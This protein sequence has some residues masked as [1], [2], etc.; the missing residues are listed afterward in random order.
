MTTSAGELIYTVDLDT[1]RLVSGSKRASRAFDEIEHSAANLNPVLSKTYGLMVSISGA[2]AVDRIIKYADAWTVVGNKVTN[3]LK[4]GQD[5]VDVQNA[6]F[7]VAQDSSTPLQ[8]VASLYGRLEPATRG[9]INSG[10]ELIK[11]TETINKAFVVSGATAEEASNAIVQLSQ[12]L[13]AGA[14]RS[15]EFNSVNEQGPRIMQGIADYMG[16]ARGELKSLAAQGKI[17]TEVVINSLRKMSSS[18]DTEFSKMND[19]F[20]MKGAQALNNLTKSL[21]SN[22]EVQSAVSA[23]GDAMV[24]LSENIDTVVTAGQAMATLYGA[25]LV[26][27]IAASTA[28]TVKSRVA[29]HAAAIAASEEAVEVQKLSASLL[30]SARNKVV[31]QKATVAQISAE[32]A[33]LSTAQ[34]SLTAQLSLSASERE[35]TAIRLQL[36]KYSQAMVAAAKAE[37]AAIAQLSVVSKEAA[38]AQ[39]TLA[40]STAAATAASRA[41]T[42][43]LGLLR[44]ALALVGGPAG[45]LLIAAAGVYY[46]YDS[47]KQANSETIE[48]AKSLDATSDSLKKLTSIQAEAAAFKLEKSIQLQSE[49]VSK[50]RDGVSKLSDEYESH[51]KTSRALFGTDKGLS[52]LR[53]ELAIEAERLEAKELEL[54][55]TKNKLHAIQQSLSGSTRDNYVLMGDLSN[56]TSI[57]T[58]IQ[59]E[60]NNVI[61]IGNNALKERANYVSIPESKVSANAQKILDDIKARTEAEKAYGTAKSARILAEKDARD[62]GVTDEKEIQL[63]S[64]A[65]AAQWEVINARKE[66]AKSANDGASEIARNNQLI[67][68]EKLKTQQLNA[69]YT[70]LYATEEKVTSGK[71]R[72]TEASAR[73]EAQQKLSSGASKE[74]IDALAKEIYAQDQM[75]AKLDARIEKE[76]KL[77]ELEGQRDEAKR[78]TEQVAFDAASPLEQIDIEEK[79]KLAKLE[80]YRQLQREAEEAGRQADIISLQEYEATKNNI[81]KQAADERAAI[82]LARN[83]M[84]LSASSDFFGGM[85]DLTGAFAGE[86][87]GAYKALF[88]IGKGFAIANAALQLQT[89]IANA[90]ALPWPENFPAIAQAVALG[91]Q[92]ASNIAGVNYGGARE[93]G[94]P[95]DAGKMYRVGEGGKPEVF[96]SGGKN[97]M[98]PGD[99]GKVIPNDQIGGGGFSQNVQVHNY[100]GENVQTKTSMD[101]KQLEVV[102][103]EVAKQI[104]QRRGGVGR[105]L[106]SS[107][108]T[109]WKAQ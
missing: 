54:S 100:S 44:G 30:T 76:R 57:A 103:G 69:Q 16:V 91:G 42:A 7:K 29:A 32:R 99:G 88:A 70:A 71:L 78:F 48:Y 79:A 34:A 6:I 1:G 81:I 22:S 18:V 105:A 104:S 15:E 107:T 47:M 23:I 50:L 56:S 17:T 68:E 5:L 65:A 4:A 73:L 58:S 2:L 62:A 35:R 25:R 36:L 106:A 20:E 49:E 28:E 74:Q 83:S 98:I 64:D 14:L 85:A 19:T 80:E 38:A 13:G 37:S 55:R 53:G 67:E 11:I 21:G 92:I 33:Y 12:A 10:D 31:N 90:S 66:G 39:A 45:L 43:S 77:K 109:K 51:A 89:A 108:A 61:G 60:F 86:Q 24:G 96:Q 52:D 63:I 59:R 3:Y 84:I 87:S 82:E 26:G 72:H 40:T 93:F 97:F 27:A 46:L 101:G 8:A 95:V 94:G 41:A 9:L 102:I 75:T